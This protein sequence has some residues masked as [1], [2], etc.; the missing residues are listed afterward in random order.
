M[1]ETMVTISLEQYTEM[2]KKLTRLEMA[3][4]QRKAEEERMNK[5]MEEYKK[6]GNKE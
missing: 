3:E 5:L 6:G 1:I 4:E 2:V